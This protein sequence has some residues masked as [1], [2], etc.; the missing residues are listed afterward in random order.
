MVLVPPHAPYL[1]QYS[2]VGVY[3]GPGVLGLALLQKHI[4][5]N[6]VELGHHLE[7]GVIGQVLQGKLALTG[8]TWVGLPQDGMAVAWHH[9]WQRNREN[10]FVFETLLH[11]EGKV[12]RLL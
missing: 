9:L 6:L 4:G 11:R 10:V 7:H 12:H 3:V 5:H 8:V 2:T 1:Q